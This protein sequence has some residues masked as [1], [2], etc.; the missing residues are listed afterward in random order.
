MAR[1]K[2]HTHDEIKA[3]A[4]NVVLQHL[5][6]ESLNSLSLRKVAAAIGY[7]PSTLVNIFGSYQGLLLA[8]AEQT[9]GELYH[10]LKSQVEGPELNVL[11]AMAIGYQA[12]AFEQ[13]RAFQLIFELKATHE[14]GMSEQHSHLIEQVFALV[15]SRIAHLLPALT[16]EQRLLVSR[17]LW[18]GVHGIVCL[19]LD[20]KLFAP[21]IDIAYMIRHHLLVQLKGWGYNKEVLCY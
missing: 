16:D 7:V 8:V 3:M 4:I 2:E 21:D 12:F 1:R 14:Q 19:A 9:L 13:P 18:G 17:S 20:D 6:V 10:R 5:Q 11:Q 15:E